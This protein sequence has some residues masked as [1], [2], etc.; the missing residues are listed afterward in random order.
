[1]F[2]PSQTTIAKKS[3]FAQST[4][5]AALGLA[6]GAFAVASQPAFAQETRTY[7]FKDFSAV[8]VSEAVDA[9]ITYGDSFAI[10]AEAKDA[11]TLE[12]LNIKQS[13]DALKIDREEE[14]FLKSLTDW[15]SSPSPKVRIQMPTISDAHV[16]AGSDLYLEGFDLER[17]G[18]H[19][20]AGADFYGKDLSVNEIKARASAGGDIE[21][22][23]T[24]GD[25]DLQASSGSDL[26]ARNLECTSVEIS[27]SSGS[28]V[29]AFASDKAAADASSGAD[30]NIYGSPAETRNNTSSGGEV[31]VH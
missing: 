29:S 18:V 25:A 12:T 30:V 9:Y 2:R 19:S 27:A 22:A 13:G 24:C 11:K 17:L 8:N 21:L 3:N 10:T 7:D 23:G 6:I 14:G 31:T 15:F 5:L 26:D 16:S 1:M 28:D 4:H 20:S